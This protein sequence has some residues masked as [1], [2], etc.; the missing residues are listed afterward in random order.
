MAEAM[1]LAVYMPPH[2]P[3]PGQA[4]CITSLYSASAILPDTFSPHAS[5]A[6]T[7]SNFFSATQPEAMVPPYTMILGRLR[8]NMAITEPGM[9][10]S[11]PTTAT[12]P[13]YDIPPITVSIE[14]AI[15]S[16]E[17]NEK[18][19]PGVPIDMPSLTPM[20]LKISPTKSAS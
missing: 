5:K 3:A 7:M 8:R 6:E 17:G 16:L 1:V 9:F 18:R 20:V 12:M 4:F 19:I 10:L 15:K 2:A 11:Q 13:S 14:S